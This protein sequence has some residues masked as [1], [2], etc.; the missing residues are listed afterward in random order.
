MT[1][2]EMLG[3]D[4]KY[5]INYPF[6]AYVA[7]ESLTVFKA[8]RKNI[9][10]YKKRQ[11]CELKIQKHDGSVFHAYLES[12]PVEDDEGRFTRCRATIQD[13]TENKQV[14]QE[15]KKLEERITQTKMLE[16][17][18]TFSGGIAH[19][20]N[21]I[22]T[23]ILGWAELQKMG[24]AGE[25]SKNDETSGHIITLV[26]R[27]ADM[28]QKLIGFAGEGKYETQPLDMTE[29]ANGSLKLTGP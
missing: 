8:F 20:L 3:I 13:I 21:N 4:R 29:I 16:S 27:A 9:A 18:G 26:G 2:S 24:T 23:G 1:G 17:L 15:R 11:T 14:E 28:V 5:L 10:E 22:L 12:I 6:S 19:E 25:P 7:P